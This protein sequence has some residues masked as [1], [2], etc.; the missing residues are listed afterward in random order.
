MGRT[1]SYEGR[2]G[3][4][5]GGEEVRGG[6]RKGGCWY[7]TGGVYGMGVKVIDDD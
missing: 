5:G 2:E 7:P 6:G 1:E 4:D 3:R